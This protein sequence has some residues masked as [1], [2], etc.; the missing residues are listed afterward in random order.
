MPWLWL[1]PREIGTDGTFGSA[2]RAGWK[3]VCQCVSAC[4]SVKTPVKLLHVECGG[5]VDAAI[6]CKPA[7]DLLLVPCELIEWS[8]HDSVRPLFLLDLQ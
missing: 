7:T 1:Q 6:C 2:S 4:V 5:R 3:V 8:W